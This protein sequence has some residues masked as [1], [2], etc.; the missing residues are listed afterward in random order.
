MVSTLGWLTLHAAAALRHEKSIA[1][2]FAPVFLYGPASQE[3]ECSQDVVF[4]EA[5]ITVSSCYCN[6]F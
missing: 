2:G 3:S 1:F 5:N 4:T 6:L